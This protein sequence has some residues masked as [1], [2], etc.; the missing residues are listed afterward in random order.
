M[1]KFTPLYLFALI[2]FCISCQKDDTLKSD[3][4]VE[5]LTIGVNC[6]DV[7]EEY[8]VIRTD[9][10]PY[11][12]FECYCASDCIVNTLAIAEVEFTSQSEP[13]VTVE[14]YPEKDTYNAS[15]NECVRIGN[16]KWK[17]DIITAVGHVA[18]V[19]ITNANSTL[20]FGISAAG[21]V[22]DKQYGGMDGIM[23]I[24]DEE[25]QQIADYLGTSVAVVKAVDEVLSGENRAFV[26]DGRP[27]IQFEGNVFWKQLRMIG[28]DPNHYV[29]D[30]PDVLYEKWT[31]AHYKYGV[32]EYER[33]ERAA[34][35]DKGAAYRSAAWGAY[36]IMGCDHR[37][38][39][40]KNVDEFVEKMYQSKGEQMSLLASYF[41]SMKLDQYLQNCDWSNFAKYYIGPSYAQGRYD[42]KLSNAYNKYK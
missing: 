37:M 29:G 17:A 16:G 10:T 26:S 4:V 7:F 33:L 24:S 40:C 34:K 2:A 41:K 36:K 42:V 1:K 19:T 25:F 22:P 18:K 3:I 31:K 30:Y 20:T 27:T 11:L 6:Y 15:L 14:D 8:E 39:M 5:N 13:N 38:C 35:I 32:K 21:G 23:Y 28:I 9:P 12:P